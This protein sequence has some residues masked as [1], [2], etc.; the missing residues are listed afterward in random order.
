ML[1]VQENL[2]DTCAS[3][4][5][6]ENVDHTGTPWEEIS[7][8]IPEGA[9]LDEILKL[10]GLDWK[11]LH[12]PTHTLIPVMKDGEE[13]GTREKRITDSF[14]LLR[15]DT[16]DILSPHVGKSYKPVQNDKAF[17]VFNDF[18]NVGDMSMETAGTLSDGK[19]IWGLAKINESFVL[20]EGERIEGYFLLVQSHKYGYSMKALFTPIR[21][22]GGTSLTQ[23]RNIRN[24]RGTT[25]TYTMPHSR[26]FDDTRIR[27]IKEFLHI[28]RSSLRDYE[29]DAR[30]M[31]D[32][33]LTEAESVRYVATVFNPE[34]SGIFNNEDEDSPNTFEELLSLEEGLN[35]TQ[36]RLISE[37][38]EYPG[39]NMPSCRET[40]WG[41]YNAISHAVDHKMGRNVNTRLESAWF[42]NNLKIKQRAFVQGKILELTGRS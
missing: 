9:S 20:S 27:E 39:S 4:P 10:A 11:V 26:K 2:F 40:V 17:T 1:P 25:G 22:P 15:G 41:Y 19:H 21:F 28:A 5:T 37:L 30:R 33:K 24:T 35:R 13:F 7:V 32:T 34:L 3:I 12:L 36:K 18:L 23:V 8:P 42:G 38:D 16:H 29:I 31:A 6:K 14:C